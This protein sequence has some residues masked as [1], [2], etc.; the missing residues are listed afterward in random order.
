MVG[1]GFKEYTRD[2]TQMLHYFSH[3]KRPWNSRDDLLAHFLSTCK[4]PWR[5]SWSFFSSISRDWWRRRRKKIRRLNGRKWCQLRER[6]LAW[7]TRLLSDATCGG[8]PRRWT[9]RPLLFHPKKWT[10]GTRKKL[11]GLSKHEDL[12]IGETNDGVVF[13]QK[14]LF[15]VIILIKFETSPTCAEWII[16]IIWK[17]NRP[18]FKWTC[19]YPKN[20]GI[21]KTRGNWRSKRPLA[22]KKDP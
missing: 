16:Y 19:R 15:N 2:W 5:C 3:R 21:S 20:H 7:A 10:G 22:F 12:D 8:F 18:H 1:E 4:L 17:V 6:H 14:W 9:G 13:L 11:G